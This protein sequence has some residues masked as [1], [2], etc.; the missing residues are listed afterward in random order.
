MYLIDTHTHL[1][2][3]EFKDDINLV[4]EKAIEKNIE[5]MYI[6]N[7]DKSTIAPMNLL[8]KKYPQHIFPMIGIHP[9]SIKNNYLEELE[10]VENE[11]KSGENKYYAIG[12]IGLDLY[13]D[14]SFVEEQKIALRKQIA[15]AKEYNLPI[16]LHCRDAFE[17]LIEIIESE[18]SKDLKGIFH[19]FTG[20]TKDAK[21]VFDLGGFKIGIGGV[22]TF[23]NSNL[24]NT[25]K[26]IGLE[27][28]VLETDSPYLAPVPYRGKRNES[29][30]IH[31]IAVFLSEY[32][33]VSL[34]ELSAITSKNALEVL[35]N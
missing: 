12:E 6:P 9:C 29:S 24:K 30:Y 34:E 32:L 10:A 18:N 21:R 1:Y 27:N 2:S 11:L 35:G 3:E 15:W 22:A 14:K 8:Q 16:I 7:V 28:V 13:W 17:P 26:E 31:E 5:R 19:C 23:K 25:L 33:S 4:I 20:D